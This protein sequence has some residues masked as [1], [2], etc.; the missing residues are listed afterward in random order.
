MGIVTKSRLWAFGRLAVALMFIAV[1]ALIA[2]GVVDASALQA[3]VAAALALAG[4]VLAWWKDNNVTILA[5]A[6]HMLNV[7]PDAAAEETA[8]SMKGDRR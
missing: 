3:A 7:G 5:I 1:V 8:V 4:L 2:M 6:R